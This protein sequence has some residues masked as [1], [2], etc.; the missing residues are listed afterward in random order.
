M[1]WTAADMPDQAGKTAVVTGAN[2]GL[3]LVISRELARAGATVVMACR[4]VK[5][6]ERAAA[7]V[8]KRAQ[9]EALDLADLD[10]VRDFAG[11]LSEA[12]VDVLV[13]NAGVMAPPRRLTA[14][15][16]ESQFGTNHLGHFALTGLLVPKLLAA[17]EPRVVTM[18]S[19][20]HRMGRINFDDLHGERLYNNWLAYGQSKLANLLFAFE[21]QR[22]ADGQLQSLAAH[23]GYSATNLQFAGPARWYERASMALTNRLIA[24]GADQGALPALYAATVTDVPGGSYIGPDGFLEARGHPHLVTAAGKAYDP[25]VAARLWEVSEALTGVRYT[26]S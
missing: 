1:K 5:K 22:R 23:P 6:G 25:E 13:N 10:S 19:G 8:G 20:G 16:F 7:E 11:R 24:Q 9:L 12:R 3:G 4:N 2:S 18:S 26:W 14:D 17:P 15:G 21:L